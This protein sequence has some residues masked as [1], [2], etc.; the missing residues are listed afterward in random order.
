MGEGQ[1]E[2]LAGVLMKRDVTIPKARPVESEY[3]HF[4]DGY[5]IGAWRFNAEKEAM[6]VMDLPEQMQRSER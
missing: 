2:H 5:L 3:S 1:L 4:K 6:K